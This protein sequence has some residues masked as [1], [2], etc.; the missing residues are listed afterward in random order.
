[1]PA[2][3]E[4]QIIIE[5]VDK[6]SAQLQ[7]IGREVQRL[8]QQVQTI[9]R[10]GGGAAAGGFLGM[11]GFGTGA[12]LAQQGVHAVTNAM[13]DFATAALQANVDL[14]RQTS[15]FVQLTGSSQR[16]AELIAA[17]RQEAARS[18]FADQETIQAGAT[19]LQLT[20][21]RKES[22]IDLVRLAERLAILNKEEGLVGA[23][24]AITE[25]QSG[26]L[27]SLVE[28]FD[29]IGARVQQLR[30]QGVPAIKAIDQALNEMGISAE[31]VDRMGRLFEG[32]VSTIQSFGL[33]L[34]QIATSGVF[35]QITAGLGDVVAAI[36]KYGDAMRAAARTTSTTLATITA[37][38]PRLLAGLIPVVGNV[39]ALVT[40]WRGLNV[41]AAQTAPH[42]EEITQAARQAVGEGKSLAL[43]IGEAGL[44][45]AELQQQATR[46]QQ[47]YDEQLRP[48]ERQLR[49]L[50]QA[51]DLQRVQNQL[52][53]NRAAVDRIRLGQEEAALRAAAGANVD[54]NAP[55]LTTRQRLIALA[56]Q[57][58]QL[59]LQQLNLEEQRRPVVQ[60]FERQIQSLRD[61]QEDELKPIQDQLNFYRDQVTT[62]QLIKQRVDLVT[63]AEQEREA[64][65]RRA[66]AAQGTGEASAEAVAESKKR[67]ETIMQSVVE[68]AQK[69]LDE[70]P[71]L[72]RLLG[73]VTT[74][75]TSLPGRLPTVGQPP[76]G[77]RG[78]GGGGSSFGGVTLHPGAVVVNGADAGAAERIKQLILDFFTAL[79]N[80]PNGDNVATGRLQGS[81]ARG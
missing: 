33:E 68:G 60:G 22:L 71:D 73:V 52:A 29:A 2:A 24:R 76:E 39:V 27:Q 28:R 9:T 57:D 48:L 49:A 40:A 17:L 3:A 58:R 62:L 46:V 14:E 54:P 55:G 42:V 50:Q 15:L 6:S 70:H 34:T 74:A 18:P 32:R 5:A 11:L 26:N 30:D 20:D 4:L 44:K 43:Q 35:A 47:S 77:A 23:A 19:L 65:T 8:D 75:V 1:M 41:Q 81:A 67:G 78:S 63:Q 13:R 21:R 36:D 72:A 79:A 53:S 80:S 31:S 69:V 61:R 10:R 37:E 64:A 51:A 38:L 25:T 12:G 7:A 56:L 16:A 45:A 66:V 59:Q